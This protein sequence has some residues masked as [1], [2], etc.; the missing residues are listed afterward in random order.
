MS[1]W[2]LSKWP[3]RWWPFPGDPTRGQA[4]RFRSADDA[5][6]NYAGSR[7][8]DVRDA[9]FANPYQD[10][11][12]AAFQRG[13]PQRRVYL[14]DVLHRQFQ[15]AA[16]RTVDSSTDLRWGTDGLGFRRLIHPNGICLT[17]TWTIFEDN[18]YSGYFANGRKGLI[19]ARVS[20][21]GTRTM[22]GEP[23]S[24]SIVGKIYPTTNPQDRSLYRPAN[25]FTQDNLGG[26]NAPRVTDVAYRTSPDVTISKRGIGVPVFARTGQV[27]GRVDREPTIRQLYPIAELGLRAGERPSVP[28]FIRLTASAGHLVINT[29]DFRDE[30]MAHIY[31]PATADRPHVQ[32]RTLDFNISVADDHRDVGSL[33][34]L[35]GT[36]RVISGWQRIGRLSFDAAVASYNGD[37]VLHFPHPPW[38]DVLTDPNSNTRT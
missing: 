18:P 38:R 23:W 17:G 25:F 35:R 28:R 36:R 19:I 26:S 27:F 24:L 8:Q 32:Q 15:N 5:S 12:G 33:F 3:S 14:I 4:Q 16:A 20:S 1:F 2:P 11:W 10:R 30:V 37:F 6:E 13:W 34:S 29:E 7:Y 9:V 21:H 22:P 31:D